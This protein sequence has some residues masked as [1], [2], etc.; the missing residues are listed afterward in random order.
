MLPHRSREPAAN[1]QTPHLHLEP[2]RQRGRARIA[3]V[4]DTP[5]R[6]DTRLALSAGPLPERRRSDE[7]TLQRA[8]DGCFEVLIGKVTGEIDQGSGRACDWDHTQ[9]DAIGAW[10]VERAMDDHQP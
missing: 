5:E 8:L 6:G 3:P 2:G 9:G 7:A 1:E 4:Q 10:E